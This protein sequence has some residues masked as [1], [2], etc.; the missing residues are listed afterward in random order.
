MPDSTP[1]LHSLDIVIIAVFFVA[2][3]LIGIRYALKKNQTAETYFLGDNLPAWALGLSMLAT[4]ISSVTFLA[5]PAAAYVLDWR[6]VVP[7]LTNP[8]LALLAIWLFVP[9][10][11]NSAKTTAYEYLHKRFGDGARLYASLM[12]LVAQ[13]LRLGAILYLLAIPIQMMTGFS[14]AWIILAVGGITAV[15]TTLGGLSAT[16]WSDVVQSFVLYLGGICSIVFIIHDIPG[17]VSEMVHV[18]AEHHKFSLGS[19][20]WNL[21]ERTFWTMIILGLTQWVGGYVADQN[22]VQRYLAAGSTREARK[23]TLLCALMSLPTWLLFFFIGTCLFAYYTIFPS[24]TVAE[25]GADYVFPHF[26]MTRLPVG[27]CGLVIAGII[28]AALSSLS[29]SLNAFS[30]VSTID[31]LQPYVFKGRSERFYSVMARVMTVAGTFIMFATGFLFL[32]AKKESFLDLS[33]K[34]AGIFG[35]VTVCFFMLG[36]FAP[37]VNRKILW[38]AFSVSFALNVYL[39]LV[40]WGWLPNFLHIHIHV[41]W[42]STLVIWVMLILALLL[43]W[44]QKTRPDS[45]PGMT[46]IRSGQVSDP[47]R[48]D[49]AACE[50]V[51]TK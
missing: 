14:P 30:T 19:M 18:A 6:Q 23:A 50:P 31:I 42:V 34:V 47:D 20:E 43:A 51:E 37:R 4:S 1:T 27:V 49:P 15:Y 2:M 7:N 41:Y 33:F 10:F 28:S 25:L 11:R 29:S 35:G 3:A 22:V 32:Y 8:L 12:F 44:I 9:F 13:S 39:A 24:A 16:V 26:I 48:T 21:S 36:F 17:G 5:F 46:L 38:Q 45:R 40:E